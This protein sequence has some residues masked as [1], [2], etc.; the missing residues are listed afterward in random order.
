ML[1][2]FGTN[3]AVTASPKDNNKMAM[4]LGKAVCGSLGIIKSIYDAIS[5]MKANSVVRAE[6]QTQF[7]LLESVLANIQENLSAH[8]GL[9]NDKAIF[10]TLINLEQIIKKIINLCQ[11]LDPS[12][13]ESKKKVVQYVKNLALSG[14]QSRTLEHLNREFLQAIAIAN[15]AMQGVTQKIKIFERINRTRDHDHLIEA[16]HPTGG[17]YDHGE[18]P[19]AVTNVSAEPQGKYLKVSWNDEENKNQQLKEYEIMLMRHNIVKYK[20]DTWSAGVC[21]KT[22]QVKPWTVC[23]VQVRAVSNTG[24]SPWSQPTCNVLMNQSPPVKPQISLVSAPTSTSLCFQVKRPELY[25]LQQIAHCIVKKQRSDPSHL[26][27]DWETEQI[28]C[29]FTDDASV[30]NIE[31]HN[32]QTTSGYKVQ[33]CLCNEWGESEPSEEIVTDPITS[34]LPRPPR[35]LFFVKVSRS[36][37]EVWLIWKPP[38]VNQGCIKRYVVEMKKKNSTWQDVSANEISNA[39]GINKLF[40]RPMQTSSLRHVPAQTLHDLMSKEQ[41]NECFCMPV[42]CLNQK[43]TYKFRVCAISLNDQKGLYSNE[44]ELETKIHPLG[45]SIIDNTVI[46]LS[47]TLLTLQYLTN[48]NFHSAIQKL[49]HIHN[50]DKYEGLQEPP[51][52]D[53]ESQV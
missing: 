9:Q 38:R 53:D 31:A 12:N 50:R 22:D 41:R 6:Y 5:T 25:N 16:L 51:D 49:V 47:I 40:L 26:R 34:M 21:I 37:N 7:S 45:R 8:H 44:L 52:S 48:S 23:N 2:T 32:F 46:T 24:S 28:A 35:R 30:C 13:K 17:V 1:L 4:A 11:D 27:M 14:S 10:T 42:T 36:H 19:A 15:L 3:R 18:P 33:I 20:C 39:T 43:T 29:K